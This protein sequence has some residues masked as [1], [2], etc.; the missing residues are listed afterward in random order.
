MNIEEIKFL[1]AG[2]ECISCAWRLD[3]EAG[4]Y[5]FDNE[6]TTIRRKQFKGNHGCSAPGRG[7]KIPDVGGCSS[8]MD[9]DE[10]QA[11]LIKKR[12]NENKLN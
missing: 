12:N 8:W 1:L 5:K 11:F 6:K 2:K 9:E 7:W 3:A 10:K 4:M